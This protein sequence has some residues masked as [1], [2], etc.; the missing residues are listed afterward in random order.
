MWYSVQ[1]FRILT[2]EVV[3][4]SRPQ[5]EKYKFIFHIL[6]VKSLSGASSDLELPLAEHPSAE[7]FQDQNTDMVG[8]K[9]SISSY[10]PSWYYNY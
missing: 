7:L 10:F 4:Y 1:C 6:Q 3:S 2:K 5:Q 9:Y 8:E